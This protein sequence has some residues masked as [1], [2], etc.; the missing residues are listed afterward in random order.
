MSKIHLQFSTK[1]KQLVWLIDPDKVN[2]DFLEAAC[3]YPDYIF[4]GGSYVSSDNFGYL[5][6]NIKRCC[7]TPLILFP[8]DPSHLKFEADAVLFLSLLSGRNAEYLIGK[9]V[10]AAPYVRRS[11]IQTIATAYLLIDAGKPTSASY[12]SGTSGI[13]HDKPDIAAATA[14]AAEMLGMSCIYLDMGSGAAKCV[15]PAMIEAVKQAVEL[16]VIVGG[17]IR[18]P[19]ELNKVYE[20]GA[21]VA[22]IGNALEINPQLFPDFLTCRDTFNNS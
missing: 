5:S 1:K 12:M 20:A 4:I 13:P 3:P 2:S 19:A 22:V 21:D 6:E 10:I 17:G 15:H 7:D 16:P 14:M 8:A 18:T 9:Q 11:G